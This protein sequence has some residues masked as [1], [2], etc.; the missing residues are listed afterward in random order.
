MEEREIILTAEEGEEETAFIE[1]KNIEIF[2]NNNNSTKGSNPSAKSIKER[3]SS[4][5]LLV[6][7]KST[8]GWSDL[9]RHS[10][11]KQIFHINLLALNIFG[12]VKEPKESLCLSVCPS[13]CLSGTNLSKA[14]NLQSQ[15]S[16]RSVQGLS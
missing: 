2:E 9:V 15:V 11:D 8:N 1:I 16:L 14:L 13:V 10:N 3:V 12:S 6:K 4:K 7:V 5:S